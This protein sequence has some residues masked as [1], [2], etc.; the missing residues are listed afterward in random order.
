MT[1][2]PRPRAFTILELL[3]VIFVI[4]VVAAIAYPTIGRMLN[5]RTVKAGVM[6]VNV[7]VK[8]A[9]AFAGRY[10]QVRFDDIDP[11]I[12]GDQPGDYSG[13]AILFT[14]EGNLRLIENVP[15]AV[16]SGAFLELVN[17]NGFADIPGREHIT[18]PA[19]IGVAGIVGYTKVNNKVVPLLIA[20]PFAVRFNERG[21]LVVSEP[22]QAGR[23]VIYD[24]DLDGAWNANNSRLIDYD[25]DAWDPKR[26]AGLNR[27]ANTFGYQLPFGTIESVIGIV[28]FDEEEL[29]RSVRLADGT[30]DPNPL[31]ADPGERNIKAATREWILSTEGPSFLRNASMLFFNRYSGAV[32]E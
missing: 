3:A 2:K 19:G 15:N 21:R 5:N 4:A 26:R 7:A 29:R 9:R 16:A 17:L 31:A 28:V 1:P 6:T 18:M 10:L 32:I 30:L 11:G 20:P 23:M 22:G 24:S 13:V 14:P 12:P 27:D 25:P 8:A